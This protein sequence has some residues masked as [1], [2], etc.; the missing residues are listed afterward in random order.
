MIKMKKH[1]PF[2]CL[3]FASA[4]FPCAVGAQETLHVVKSGVNAESEN[5]EF[6]LEF[7]K[8]LAQ[9]SPARLETALQLETD[10]KTVVPQNIVAA[11]ASL[12]LFPL[13]RG[14][15]YHLQVAGL[16]GANEERMAAY[17]QPF[18]IPDRSPMLAFTASNGGVNGFGSYNSAM[19]LRAVNV[20]RVKLDVYRVTDIETMAHVWQ[21]RA[22]TS[23]APSE[24]A[25]LARNKGQ[26][27]WQGDIVFDAPPN[28]TAEQKVSLREKMP[29]LA[30]GLYLIVAD[31]GKTDAKPANKGLAPLAAAWFT[32]SDF[33]LRAMRDDSGIHVFAANM[34]AAGAKTDVHLIAASKKPEQLAEAQVGGDGIGLIAYPEHLEDRNEIATVVGADKAGNVAFADIETLPALAKQPDLGAID[35]NRLFAAPGETVDVGLSMALPENAGL[36]ASPSLLH[37]SRGDFSYAD[38]TVPS[39][40]QGKAGVSF[41]APATQGVW[42][43]R[44]QKGDGSTLASAPL[45]VTANSDAPHLEVTSERDVLAEDARWSITIRSIAASGKPA[46]LT[47]GHVNIVWQKLDPATFGWKDYRFGTAGAIAEAPV[48]VADF[49]TDLQGN[50]QLHLALPAHPQERGLYQAVLHAVADPDSGIAEASPLVLPLRPETTII[51]IKPLAGSKGQEEARFPQNGIARF[52]LIGLSS[53]GKP[54]DVSGLSYQ[55]YEEGRSFAWYQD[56]G[57]WNYKP[58]PQLRPIGGGALSIRGDASSVLEWPVTAGNYR[59]EILDQNGK[60][61]ARTPFS[62]GWD[63]TGETATAMPLNVKL[64]KILQPGHEAAAHVMLPEAAMLTAIV[65]DTKIRKAIHEFRDK[66][67]NVVSFTPDTDWQDSVNLIVEASPQ[68]DKDVSPPEPLRAV[69][70]A[71]IARGKSGS[72]DMAPTGVSI[73]AAH[74]P[75]ALV[76]RKDESAT[77]TFAIENLGDAE[78]SFYYVFTATPGLKIEKDESGRLTL[79]GRQSQSL[80][81]PVS[82]EQ[83]GIKELR[84]EVTSERAKEKNGAIHASRNWAVAVLPKA[85]ALRSVAT[86]PVE[87]KQSLLSAALKARS[88][89]PDAPAVAFVSRRPMDG[90]AEILSFVFNAHPFTTAELALSLDA[91]RQWAGTLAQSGFVPDFLIA[92]RQQEKLMQM[93]RHQ[94]AD[95]GFGAMR[96]EESTLEDT[97][98]ALT[99]LGPDV[100]EPAKPARDLAVNWVK[101][102]LANTWLNEKEREGRAAAYAALATANAIEPSS[103]HY[104][105]D[106]SATLRLPPVAEA[107]IAAAFKAIHDPD[108]AAFWI[109]KMLDENGSIKTIPLLNALAATDALSSDDVHAAMAAMT[110]ALRRGKPVDV[111]D[112]AALLR[113][114]A[115]DNTDAGK[116]R[117]T[118]GGETRDVTGVL[119]LRLS[120]AATALAHNEEAQSLSVTLVAEKNTPVSDTAVTR[121]IYRMNG[122]EL[123]ASA[124][125]LRDE[126]YMIEL[127]G[128]VPD[129]AGNEKILLQDGAA[130][131]LRP[132][133]CPLSAKGDA[134]PFIPWFTTQHLAAT[135]DCE[136]SPHEMNA[137]LAPTDNENAAFSLV[138][139]AYIDAA[140]A[141]DIPPPRLR[142]LK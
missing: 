81:L 112:A 90:L 99:A 28:A 119:A 79:G 6:C 50:A 89:G 23:L 60:I 25:Y 141:A 39:L 86:A 142:I 38:F 36:L 9:I 46:P 121:H 92:A 126:P 61:V 16:R 4:L 42:T 14:Q 129:L 77:L 134:P 76:L 35:S 123:S 80:S 45:R 8:P 31:A 18:T 19:N 15:F 106:T 96:G 53:D 94:N 73:V 63:S 137:V 135:D 62:A 26:R 109:K 11:G 58:E 41:A 64:P 82:G 91:M 100:S 20:A 116:G 83:A 67:D 118:M 43:M 17:S 21:E 3:L 40:T 32:K 117:L 7:D 95:G 48:R 122:V 29:D 87:H 128:A 65:A 5:A 108:A 47:G 10:D 84:L 120:D 125:P 52:A 33:S 113:A 37:L 114:I 111:K 130:N 44:W 51:G 22:Q 2:S 69:A 139:F 13:E 105:S 103:L 140:S 55:V 131:M 102:R 98:A 1:I 59:L 27:V 107:N 72:A 54:R 49:L 24:S 74:S 101:Q 66:G 12:C 104:F 127:K 71:S 34:E 93:L 88:A 85:D 30:P 110:D 133:G 115:T 68:S 136:F 132:I 78:E 138:Y 97:A 70:E 56:A 57:N 75:S 124:K